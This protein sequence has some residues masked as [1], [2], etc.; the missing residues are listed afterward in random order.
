MFTVTPRAPIPRFG[1]F[2]R[3]FTLAVPSRR[4]TVRPRSAHLKLLIKTK[5]S[6]RT[7]TTLP[8]R[9]EHLQTRMNTATIHR[10]V[11]WQAVR[12][13]RKA[14]DDLRSRLEFAPSSVTSSRPL[15]KISSAARFSSF[16]RHPVTV[17]DRSDA[18]HNSECRQKMSENCEEIS[19][20]GK[21]F[22][23]VLTMGLTD[24]LR[25]RVPASIG[26]NCA[27]FGSNSNFSPLH[28]LRSFTG[29]DCLTL[30]LQCYTPVHCTR[31]LQYSVTGQAFSIHPEYIR[32]II[33]IHPKLIDLRHN[34]VFC[35]IIQIYITASLVYA[36]IVNRLQ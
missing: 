29:H 23:I 30:Q 26:Q 5:L 10:D 34:K 4:L 11:S 13:S 18:K 19:A 15:K 14:V 17:F 12:S 6:S 22:R 25:L 3:A 32:Y 36:G 21:S 31:M 16:S 7:E 1:P 9:K 2:P 24:L 20:E 35:E 8:D 27:I 28:V 33:C